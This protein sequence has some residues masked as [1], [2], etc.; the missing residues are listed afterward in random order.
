M[1]FIDEQQVPFLQIGQQGCQIAGPF[2][3]RAGRDAQIDAQ[4]I[5]DDAG[6]GRLAQA[7]RPVQEHVVQRFLAQFRRFNEYAQIFLGL[8]LADIFL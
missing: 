6:H 5:G 4:L 3:R 1:D 8:G 7:R 2:D